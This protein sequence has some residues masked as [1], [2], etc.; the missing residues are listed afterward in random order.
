MNRKQINL[1]LIFLAVAIVA[2]IGKDFVG[3]KAGKT[4]ENP[5]AYNID[6][7]RKVD[8]SQVLFIE[9]HSFPVRADLWAGIACV[10]SAIVIANATE[11]QMYNYSGRLISETQLIDS[12]TCISIA[13]DKSFWIG[14]TRFVAHYDR[15]GQLISKFDAVSGNAIFTSIVLSGENI[16]VADAG[17]RIVHNYTFD[18]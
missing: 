2:L 16:Y 14:M 1:A 5:Y 12:A 3:K 9:K 8:S 7:Y 17:N 11:L 4:I 10:D 13:K 18:D 15:A 6:E